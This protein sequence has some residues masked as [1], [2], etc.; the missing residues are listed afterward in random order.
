MV[1]WWAL[2]SLVPPTLQEPPVILAFARG[3]GDSLVLGNEHPD[4]RPVLAH[5]LEVLA[6]ERALPFAAGHAIRAGDVDDVVPAS[7]L[8]AIAD[9]DFVIAP[10]R[11][12][13]DD[14]LGQRQ[15]L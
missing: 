4:E 15:K 14:G 3:V 6:R 7:V 5:A 10:R 13:D 1:G 12:V 2:G 8:V 11:G 9:W